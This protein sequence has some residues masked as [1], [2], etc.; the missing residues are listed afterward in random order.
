MGMGMHLMRVRQM[1]EQI[2]TALQL[3]V[4][5]LERI[6]GVLHALCHRLE[7]LKTFLLQTSGVIGAT[8]FEA[9]P[10]F[11]VEPHAVAAGPGGQDAGSLVS[12]CDGSE[13]GNRHQFFLSADFS[14]NS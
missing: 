1:P 12:G 11:F 13:I 4:S 6:G 9:P 5:R 8:Q 2:Q 10:Q 3:A 7:Q 14:T